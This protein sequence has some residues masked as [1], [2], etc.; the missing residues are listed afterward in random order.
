MIWHKIS[1]ECYMR[2]PRKYILL[3]TITVL[4]VV[5]LLANSFLLDSFEGTL[6]WHADT[7]GD[8]ATLSIVPENAT[9]GKNSLHAVFQ[10]M[11]KG[12][13]IIYREANADLS[14]STTLVLDITNPQGAI[15]F[16]ATAFQT[17]SDWVYYESKP[18]PLQPGINKDVAFNLTSPEYC[19]AE[20]QWKFS[21]NLR[22]R[23]QVQRIN[24]LIFTGSYKTGDLYIDNIRLQQ[25]KSLGIT[26]ETAVTSKTV[27]ITGF[28]DE[29]LFNPQSDA[30]YQDI[31]LSNEHVTEGHNS[32]KWDYK[33]PPDGRV[34]IML[35]FQENL[36]TSSGVLVDV[37]NDTKE[38]MQF[39]IAFCMENS[40]DWY[41]S[42][43]V[44]IHPG[45]N[46]NIWIDLTTPTWRTKK[47]NYTYNNE[48]L[49]RSKK[50]K[51]IILVLYPW[52]IRTGSVYVDNLRLIKK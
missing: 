45:P 11:G 27:L 25:T 3:L 28:E 23:D 24:F 48:Y 38:D 51:T 46:N 52:G 8:P 7:I 31:S 6:T 33:N 39:D 29:I 22:N 36:K 40:W 34:S 49:D 19:C 30:K 41:E 13:A 16:I 26:P 4:L 44:V 37:Y 1:V 12:E 15:V 47:T 32:M 2:C 20:S 5:P 42:P 43:K 35:D 21:S 17:G 14:R 50:T 10:N 9:E 18:V